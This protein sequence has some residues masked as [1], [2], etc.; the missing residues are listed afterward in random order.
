MAHHRLL[1]IQDEVTGS[2]SKWVSALSAKYKLHLTVFSPVV[3]FQ[4]NVCMKVP[5]V[6]KVL[7]SNF[8]SS[9]DISF[10]KHVFLEVPDE[11]IM[12]KLMSIW[13]N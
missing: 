2:I 9:V 5:N 10:L 11:N 12:V 6:D 1:I 3:D 13:I 7:R 4:E 8:L